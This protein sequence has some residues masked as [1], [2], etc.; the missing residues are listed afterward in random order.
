[1]QKEAPMTVKEVR[2][3]LEDKPDDL[4]IGISMNGK[5]VPLAYSLFWVHEDA[6]WRVVF[7]GPLFSEK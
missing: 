3:F 1:M 4:E 2:K 7:M 5:V 6:P